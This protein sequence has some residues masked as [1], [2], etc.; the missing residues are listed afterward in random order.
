MKL[1]CFIPKPHQLSNHNRPPSRGRFGQGGRRMMLAALTAA[2]SLMATPALAKPAKSS[3]IKHF[4]EMFGESAGSLELAVPYGEAHRFGG[5][6]ATGKEAGKF[7]LPV[8]FAVDQAD[9]STGDKNAVYVL[10]RTVSNTESGELDYRLQKLSSS[11]AVLGTATLPVQKYTDTSQFTDA[12]PMISLAVDS[13]N[14]RVYAGV[15]S[16]VDDGS[17]NFVPVTEELVA[18]STK[19][20]G[21]K[22]LIAASGFPVDPLTK[23]GLVAG[24]SVLQPEEA[25]KDLYA[26]EAISVDPSN[27]DVV[28]EAQQGVQ[29]G[30]VGGPTILQRVTTEGSK[31]GQL[32]GSWVADETTAPSSQQGDGLFTATDGSFGIDLFEEEGN[33]SRLADVKPNFGTPEAS[34]LAPDQSEG[35]NRDEA[36]TLDNGF[37][38]NY[39]EG[40]NNGLHGAS[41]LEAYAAGSPITQLSN[42]LYAARYGQAA[43]GTDRQSEVEPWNG[44]PYFWT[45]A[46]HENKNVA[47]MGVRLFG[48]DGTV[49]GT[50]GGQSQGQPCN[51]DEEQ[52]AVAAGSNGSLFVLTQPN[53]ENGNSD[54][55][56]IE[57]TPG[58]GG[59]PGR[60][61]KPSATMTVNG[62]SGTSFS[63]PAGTTVTFEDTV[64]R[65]GETPFRFDWLLVKYWSF[66]DLKT[67]I[68]APEYT[69]PASS[70]SKT[71]T[72]KGLYRVLATVYGDYGI[73]YITTI[74]V[75]IT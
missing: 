44:L 3:P 23:A 40:P 16:I 8:G 71:F 60:C 17:G 39:R 25:S 15:Q 5:F 34:L 50:I 37:T 38:T 45:Q 57:Y 33:I 28:I 73:T 14:H 11:G 19:P 13:A 6:D 69:W 27:H 63:F 1:Y 9:S 58:G 46:D 42:G 43:H 56:V 32:D 51:I 26:P 12:H 67:Q 75:R 53:P 48:P 35:L 2:L 7:V 47:N 49:V 10:D 24:S 29:S 18:W 22:Q 70:F 61:P 65:K 74:K 62:Q 36:P 66:E 59:A 41:D 30:P 4:S 72:Q 64:E 31:S 55:Q 54:D 20:S 68:E 21:K 52:L